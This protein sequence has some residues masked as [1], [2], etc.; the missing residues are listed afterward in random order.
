MHFLINERV[1][2]VSLFTKSLKINYSDFYSL[3]V[4]TVVSIWLC[5]FTAS[6]DA[7]ETK[8]TEAGQL[9]ALT[10]ELL[11]V[12]QEL[13]AWNKLKPAIERLVENE[14]DLALLISELSKVV[15]IQQQPVKFVVSKESVTNKGFIEEFIS[16]DA[17]AKKNT[18][19]PKVVNKVEKALKNNKVTEIKNAPNAYGIHLSSYS[20]SNN[21]KAGWL[22]YKKRFHDFLVDGQPMKVDFVSK[23]KSFSRLVYGPYSSKKSALSIC[24]LLKVEGQ[25]CAVV[26]YKGERI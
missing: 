11:H 8:D 15:E 22:S 17:M 18:I 1:N 12:K 6:S 21:L 2:E 5:A 7:A 19:K 9:V 3:V 14:A 20:K 26:E 10:A 13:E 24:R 16:T 4:S 23:G 25:Y